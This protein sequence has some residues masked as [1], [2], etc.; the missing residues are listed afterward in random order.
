MKSRGMEAWGP[1]LMMGILQSALVACLPW[2]IERTGLSAGVWSLILS[3]GMMPVLLAAPLWGGM[4]DRVGA[5]R[6]SALASL[7]VVA[8]YGLLL[9]TL[10]AGLQGAIAAAFLVMAR[11]AHGVGVGG[12]FPAAQRL[13]I[14]GASPE[15]W[16][17]RLS[18][19]QM[20]VHA[21]RLAG[22]AL[23]GLAAWL[24]M[25]TVLLL[26]GALAVLLVLGGA[27]ERNHDSAEGVP[28]SAEPGSNGRPTWIGGAPF[29]LMALLL[30]AWVGAIQ[31]ML[32]PLLTDLAGVS[33]EVG[34][35]L[36]AGALVLASVVGLIFGPMVHRLVQAPVTLLV[37]WGGALLAASAILASAQS[38][39]AI[40]GGIGVLAF[41]AAVL[42]PWYGSLLRQRFPQA[43]GQISGRLTS[44]HT[45][46]YI[47]GTLAGGGL[48]E[49]SPARPLSV[50]VLLAAALI[51]LAAW[52]S[53]PTRKDRTAG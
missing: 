11:A 3:A 13:A 26:A 47:I 20:A 6:V 40:Y 33:A 8:G 51:L 12:V 24:G 44:T 31:F 2:L 35:S 15:A 45:L 25:M 46:G 41:G 38:L 43:Q 29:Y 52:V 21:G 7:L 18:R 23:I 14:S 37:I 27:R 4:V 1:V 32:G 30:T 22:P 53:M 19:L 48:L 17:Y 36:T 34:S 50:S 9:V 42:T 5:G 10:A 49:A 39:A 16:G 28:G